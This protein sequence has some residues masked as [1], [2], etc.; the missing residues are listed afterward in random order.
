MG[1]REKRMTKWAGVVL[2]VLVILIV[3]TI[4]T[5]A[6]NKTQD[7]S[8]LRDKVTNLQV[9]NLDLQT[10]NNILTHALEVYKQRYHEAQEEILELKDITVIYHFPRATGRP[11]ILINY[12]NIPDANT[13]EVRVFVIADKTNEHSYNI[14]NYNCVDYAVDLH[15][16][17]EKAGF[18]AGVV[19]IKF[20]QGHGHAIT[21]FVTRDGWL[22]VDNK[23]RF[24]EKI[25]NDYWGEPIKSIKVTW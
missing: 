15:N 17:A 21:V 1:Y 8:P 11:A 9:A 24:Y 20:E 4:G 14:N 6:K 16:N 12:P 2:A 10:T 18:I 19:S 25:G 13:E 7:I 5:G 23:D 3:T 22:F